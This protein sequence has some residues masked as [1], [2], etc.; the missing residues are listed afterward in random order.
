MEKLPLVSVCL[1]AYNQEKYVEKAIDSI[2]AQTYSPLEIILSDDCST[3]NTLIIIKA[4]L[5]YK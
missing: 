4:L 2:F 1:I 5:N 3:D